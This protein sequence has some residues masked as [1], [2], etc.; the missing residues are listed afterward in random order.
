MNLPTCP[1]STMYSHRTHLPGTL[2]KSNTLK[3]KSRA[4]ITQLCPMHSFCSCR[5]YPPRTL[6]QVT[7]VKMKVRIIHSFFTHVHVVPLCTPEYQHWALARLW[8]VKT[9]CLS[10]KASTEGDSVLERSCWKWAKWEVAAERSYWT[11][12]NRS[13]DVSARTSKQ[14]ITST[15]DS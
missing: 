5:T 7:I 4:T 6:P 8:W 12:H 1:V 11:I 3:L 14:C 15:T 10:F 9:K 2:P 13:T